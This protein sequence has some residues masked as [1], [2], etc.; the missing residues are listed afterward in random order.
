MKDKLTAQDIMKF[1]EEKPLF[2]KSEMDSS[3]L[4]GWPTTKKGLYTITDMYKYFEVKNY[5]PK[6]VDDVIYKF[7]QKS[8][9]DSPK[10][11]KGKTHILKTIGVHNYNSE[12]NQKFTYYYFDIIKEKALELKSEYEMESKLLMGNTFVKKTRNISI[13]NANR[14]AKRVIKPRVKKPALTAN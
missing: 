4:Y 1:F 9:S 3:K 10:M 8:D 12:Y 13:A 5:T 7:F 14:K 11:E 2:D 6:D